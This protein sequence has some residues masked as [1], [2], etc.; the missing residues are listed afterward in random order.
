MDSEESEE[1]EHTDEG[2]SLGGKRL[3]WI[4]SMR[5][6]MRELLALPAPA[7]EERDYLVEM[8]VPPENIDNC[9]LIIG[10][11][12]RLAVDGNMRAFQELRHIVGDNETHLDR[13]LKLA[14][15][16]KINMQIE[17]MKRKNAADEE[18]TA[19]DANALAEALEESAASLWQ[20][21]GAGSIHEQEE[22]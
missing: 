2:N 15:L 14:Q 3:Q 10:V 19:G 22:K 12:F 13:R 4:Y 8:G 7:C 18:N 9:M 16:K 17:D 21:G 11:L 1:S 6:R 20:N 5:R